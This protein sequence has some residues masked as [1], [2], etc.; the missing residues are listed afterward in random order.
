ADLKRVTKLP[1]IATLGNLD[2]MHPT[3]QSGWAFRTWTAL[4]SRLSLSPNHGLVCGFTSS[5]GGQGRSTWIRLLAKAASQCGFRV[6]TIATL[7]SPPFMQ[8][9][10]K[11]EREPK[12]NGEPT[13][14]G[15]PKPNGKPNGSPLERSPFGTEPSMAVMNN[16]LIT[17]GQVTEKLTGDHAEPQVHIPLPGWVWSLER[18]KQWQGALKQ[19][20]NIENIVILV[21]LPPACD[22]EAVLLAENIPNIVWL[23][24]SSKADATDSREQLQTLRDARCNLVGSVM[25]RAPA[26]ARMKKRFS[27]WVGVWPLLA[28]I[29]LVSPSSRAQTNAPATPAP[30][31]R[32]VNNNDTVADLPAFSATAMR[33]RAEWQKRLT[34]GPGDT[35]SIAM[36]GEPTFVRPEV[37]VGPDG[38]LS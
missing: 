29:C 26:A 14:N 6:L 33:H 32:S 34:L 21:E 12:A 25:N 5:G 1:V 10:H 22:P 15:E 8:E 2:K 19:W 27:R 4:Q 28:C 30:P 13:A 31:A 3:T 11:E 38:R 7:P 9:D 20:R 36:Y 24:D 18:R 37:P 16:V 17:P 35:L 23:A